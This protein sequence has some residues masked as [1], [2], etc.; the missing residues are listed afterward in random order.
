ME[1]LAQTNRK[2]LIDYLPH[3]KSSFREWWFIS[4]RLTDGS[5][6]DFS[7]DDAS[8]LIHSLFGA[9]EG[10]IYICNDREIFVLLRWGKQHNPDEIAEQVESH[11]PAGTCEVHVHART[12]A[13]IDKLELLIT[14]QKPLG[15]A[16]LR[17]ARQEKII[18]VADDDLFMRTQVKGFVH[19]IMINGVYQKTT[20]FEAADGNDVVSI[21]K[22]HVPDVLFLDLH[23]PNKD[24][25][26]ILQEIQ[27]LDRQAYVVMMSSDNTPKSME[28]LLKEG[29]R[30]FLTKPFTKELL[31]DYIKKCPTLFHS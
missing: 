21:Y 18:L 7:A 30:G 10:K 6:K 3:V 11:L 8:R 19:K 12:Q 29:A 5:D 17:R 28:R 26:S 14:Y 20:I 15:L 31:C 25:F 4:V 1:I 23:M 22:K 27:A 24:G 13:G 16:D 9:K 2:E